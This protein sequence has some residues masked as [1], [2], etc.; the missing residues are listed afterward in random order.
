MRL[1]FLQNLQINF[2]CK[3]KVR[4]GGYWLCDPMRIMSFAAEKAKSRPSE[5]KKKRKGTIA[6]QKTTNAIVYVSGGRDIE[7]A[8]HLLDYCIARKFEQ[9]IDQ[10]EKDLMGCEVH[11]FAPSMQVRLS[12]QFVFTVDSTEIHRLESPAWTL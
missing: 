6:E 2:T 5:R 4:I 7:F 10:K 9:H 12:I 1:F 3:Y 8:H 11:I